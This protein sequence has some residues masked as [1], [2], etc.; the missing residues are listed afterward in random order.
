MQR[1]TMSFQNRRKS[2]WLPAYLGAIILMA[3]AAGTQAGLPSESEDPALDSEVVQFRTNVLGHLRR[4]ES[5][6]LVEITLEPCTDDGRVSPRLASGEFE[7]PLNSDIVDE[8]LCDLAPI[9]RTGERTYQV[10]MSSGRNGARHVGYEHAVIT[11]TYSGE[12]LQSV[13]VHLRDRSNRIT[14][15]PPN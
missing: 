7:I 14:S 1:L 6:E 13:T 2:Y 8:I 9:G 5:G 12:R 11:H 4:C 3:T 15:A 10:S